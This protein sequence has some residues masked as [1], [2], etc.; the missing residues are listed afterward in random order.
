M[1]LKIIKHGKYKITSEMH[2]FIFLLSDLEHT[3]LKALMKIHPSWDVKCGFFIAQKED[4]HYMHT[5]GEMI[6]SFY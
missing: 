4:S 1:L 6:C 2:A 3:R 5:H